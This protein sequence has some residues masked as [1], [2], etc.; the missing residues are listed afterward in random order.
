[1]LGSLNTWP[2]MLNPF[3]DCLLNGSQKGLIYGENKESWS[4]WF[5][6]VLQK[7]WYFRYFK[8]PFHYKR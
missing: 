3:L 7:P 2:L 1:M 6:F 4:L 8:G 5:C